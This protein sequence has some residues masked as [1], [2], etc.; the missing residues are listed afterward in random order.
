M[1]YLKMTLL[2]KIKEKQLAARKAQLTSK[3]ELYTTLLG[4]A[5]MVGKTAGNRES[6]D[7]EVLAV[8]VKFKKNIEETIGLLKANRVSSPAADEVYAYTVMDLHTQAD[9]LAEFL[10]EK[11]TGDVLENELR[12]VQNTLRITTMKDVMK[13]FKDNHAGAYDGKELSNLLRG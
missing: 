2:E 8:V 4:E 11:L 12:F 10:P 13:Y 3:A 7:A 9:L 5:Q 6:T 1:G